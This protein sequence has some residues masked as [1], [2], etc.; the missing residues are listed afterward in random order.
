DSQGSYT[1]LFVFVSLPITL[2]GPPFLFVTGLGGG[3]GYNRQLVPPTTFDQIPS[4]FLV[5]AI[6][7][8]SLAND[9]M[10]ALVSMGQNA[11]PRRGSFWLAAGVRFNSYVVVHTVAVAYVSL[12]RGLEIGVLGVSRLQ[13]PPQDGDEL[14]NIEL[15]LKA[16]F[17]AAE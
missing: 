10:A 12:D 4:F 7:D 6:D 9:P 15:A 1:S 14:V 8:D 16:R 11:P 5:E 17:S 13:L 3:A 2:G